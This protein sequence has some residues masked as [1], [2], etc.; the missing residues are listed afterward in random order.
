MSHKAKN[1]WRKLE[2][3]DL[4][5]PKLNLEYMETLACGLYQIKLAPG[6]IV[7]HQNSDGDYEIWVYQ[8]NTDLIRGQIHSRHK[9]RTKYNVWIQ[10]TTEESDSPVNGY[11]CAWPA[12]NRTAGMCAHVASILYFLGYHQHVAVSKPLQSSSREYSKYVTSYK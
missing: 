11:N 4:T 8:H 1:E 7:E 12:G 2:A 9:R 5:F 6:Y 3:S 10:Y